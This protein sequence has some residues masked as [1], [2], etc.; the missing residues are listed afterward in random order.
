MKTV[1]LFG[2]SFDPPHIGHKAVVRAAF[3]LKDVQ[4]VIVM[5]TYL[6][7]FKSSSY[8]SADKRYDLLQKMFKDYNDV[9]ISR[10]EIDKKEKVA[11][12]ISVL[13]LLKS[14][15]KIYLIIGADNLS[16]LKN[17]HRYQELEQK[18]TFV[19][20]QRD[21]ILIPKSYLTLNIDEDISSTYIRKKQEQKYCKIELNI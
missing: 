9:E 4:K 12:I 5:P 6:S 7:P 2:G 1:A 17:W 16:S 21:G 8:H 19:V 14:Y 13:Y 15:S 20:A 11:S 10:F 3:N 18:V